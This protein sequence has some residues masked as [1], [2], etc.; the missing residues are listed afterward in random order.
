MGRRTNC[1]VCVKIGTLCGSPPPLAGLPQ[2]QKP[3]ASV[4]FVT[5]ATPVASHSGGAMN[6]S[7]WIG[8]MAGWAMG[9][10][11]NGPGAADVVRQAFE[12]SKDREVEV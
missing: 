5:L 2:S 11:T 8:D 10:R 6:A 3:W 9:S 12:I 7:A 4:P 1:S